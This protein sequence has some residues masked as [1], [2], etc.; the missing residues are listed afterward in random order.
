M[1]FARVTTL[2]SEAP[3]STMPWVRFGSFE[4]HQTFH[5]IILER[6]VKAPGGKMGFA[7]NG[8]RRTISKNLFISDG[9]QFTT[10]A[11]A[12]PTLTIVALAIRQADYI[13]DQIAKQNIWNDN[14]SQACSARV[15]YTVMKRKSFGY[16]GKTVILTKISGGYQAVINGQH[17]PIRAI[18]RTSAMIAIESIINAG[19]SIWVIRSPVSWR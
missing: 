2:I 9:S 16:A 3:W 11:A 12:N 19:G 14:D 15:V 6:V 17:F 10:G 4:F 18:D 7:I 1:I 8:V 13:A 5:V